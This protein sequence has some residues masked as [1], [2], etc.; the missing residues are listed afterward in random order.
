MREVELQLMNE[1]LDKATA[2]EDDTQEV[3]DD[4]IPGTIT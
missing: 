1:A 4:F 3:T 2:I